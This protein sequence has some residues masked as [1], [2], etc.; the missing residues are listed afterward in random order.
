MTANAGTCNN[1]TAI[2]KKPVIFKRCNVFVILFRALS[3]KTDAISIFEMGKF[4]FEVREN[5]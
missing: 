4:N 5:Q 3:T 2:K 1:I